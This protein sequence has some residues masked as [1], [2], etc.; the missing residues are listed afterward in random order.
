MGKVKPFSKGWSD[1]GYLSAENETGLLPHTIPK[2]LHQV[3]ERPNVQSKTFKLLEEYIGE[4]FCAF[5]V[6]E[7]CV[8]KKKKF[9]PL[10]KR[11]WNN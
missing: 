11:L 7:D 9:K 5:G 4:C 3:E 6:G 8:I 2:N 10:G 1:N